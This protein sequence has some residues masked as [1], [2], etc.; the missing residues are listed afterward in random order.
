MGRSL[1]LRILFV[2][3]YTPNRI[4]TRS[5]HLVKA[6]AALGHRVTLAAIW[7]SEQELAEAKSLEP[8]LAGLLLERQSN[9]RS[10]A[11]CMRALPTF[12]PMQAHYSWNQ[13]FLDQIVQ[14]LS[15][16]PYDV[17][18][19]EHLRGVRYGLAIEQ[20][21]DRLAQHQPP[22]VWDSVDCISLLFQQAAE[23]SV[24]LRSRLIAKM[25]LPRTKRYEGRVTATFRRV[26]VTSEADRSA[27][28][29]LSRPWRGGETGNGDES[30]ESRVQVVPNGVDLEYFS[31]RSE[32]HEPNSIVFSGKMS[33]HANVTAAVGFVN[34]VMP[35][36]WDVAPE[37][38]LWIVGKDPAEAVRRL[39]DCDPR[40]ASAGQSRIVV[41]GTGGA[42][43][44]QPQHARG[45]RGAPGRLVAART[46]RGGVRARLLLL[47]GLVLACASDPMRYRLTGSGSTWD[48]A[49]DD[50][51][52][53]DVRPRYPGLFEVV[54][55]P[56][57]SDDP[58][59]L[60]VR[61]DLEHV[62]VDRRNYDALNAVAIA[63]FEINYRSE[64]SRDSQGM[65][66]LTAG[67]RAAKIVGVPWR[68]Y[69]DVSDPQLRDAILDFFA[70][71]ASGEKLATQRTRGRIVPIVASLESK[72]ADPGRRERILSILHTLEETEASA[73]REPE[74]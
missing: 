37:A 20:A 11:N 9:Q 65:E 52:L 69:G 3:P 15:E 57:R 17:V 72:E 54:L 70:D 61:E 19:V 28:L 63:Y 25:E 13:R 58:D 71:V 2:A 21:R 4:R 18:H 66:F 40:A 36:I 60:A 64:S 53:E 56:S 62:P 39:V 30:L 1:Q 50:A 47:A 42:R 51:V 31:P 10:I 23:T 6:L 45:S 49:G 34:N 67:F 48:V 27:L 24:T 38:K 46:G 7:T 26:I 33:Y 5:L 55:D 68:A 43:G 74:E 8:D 14:E 29:E 22:V 32:Q 44:P 35:K 73:E 16:R 41:T 59:L 12:E